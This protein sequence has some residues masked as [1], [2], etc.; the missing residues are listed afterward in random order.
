[1]DINKKIEEIRQ[2]PEHVRMQYVLF[3]V[4]AS[5]L[6]LFSFW[7]FSLKSTLSGAFSGNTQSEGT[8]SGGDKTCSTPS[9]SQDSSGSS[10]NIPKKSINDLIIPE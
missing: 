1:M 2:K 8:C 9:K 4:G 6:I 3:C 10:E 7:L 5:M